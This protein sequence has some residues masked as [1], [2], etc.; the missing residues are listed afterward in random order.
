M[1]KASGDIAVTFF[2]QLFNKIFSEGVYPEQWSRSV[3]VP[4]FEKGNKDIPNNYGG[5]YC[6]VWP[7]SATRLFYE[8]DRQ[9]GWMSIFILFY[10]FEAQAGFRKGSFTID[11]IYT[12]SA[13]TEKY[14]SR[15]GGKLYVAFIDLRKAFDSVDRASLFL[16]FVKAGLSGLFLECH[17]S[18]LF[19]CTCT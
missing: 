19:L 2:T 5:F 17:Q 16:T 14:L 15:T 9:S 18:S 13:T 6:R 12:L 3:I 10:F 1:L 11:H 7:S 8:T 4:L